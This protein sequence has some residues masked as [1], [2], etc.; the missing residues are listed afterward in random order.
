MRHPENPG[1]TIRRRAPARANRQFIGMHG[2]A[3]NAQ[4]EEA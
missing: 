2:I 3:W 4:H 1:A